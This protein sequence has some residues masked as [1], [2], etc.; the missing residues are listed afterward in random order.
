VQTSRHCRNVQFVAWYIQRWGHS[1]YAL[2][3]GLNAAT[4]GVIALAAVQLSQ[5]AI[6]DK[7]T[8]ILLFLGATAGMLHNGLWFFPVL[9]FL[10]GPCDYHLGF[11]MLYPLFKR[12]SGVVQRI[13]RTPESHDVEMSSTDLPPTNH[14]KTF[15]AV[16]CRTT[17]RLTLYLLK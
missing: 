6:T 1:A 11:S 14:Y 3:S 8:R 7:V 5:K 12:A 9:I 15:T 17:R 2:P 16:R 10:A 4:V 13:R